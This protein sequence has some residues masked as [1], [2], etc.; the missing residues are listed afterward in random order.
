MYRK[1]SSRLVTSHCLSGLE[2]LTFFDAASAGQLQTTVPGG[3]VFFACQYLLPFE[4]K[5]ESQ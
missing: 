4:Q 3:S 2:R 5:H 1:A